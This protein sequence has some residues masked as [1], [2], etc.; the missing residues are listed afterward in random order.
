MG[1]RRGAAD[2]AAGLAGGVLATLVLHPLDFV[3]IQ[4]QVTG[5]RTGARA[6][7]SL[8]ARVV[9]TQGVRGLYR[10]AA[11]NI[12]GSGLAWG[13]YFFGYELIK[14]E[15]RGLVGRPLGA[16]EH[17]LA[18]VTAGSRSHEEEKR[19]KKGRGKKEGRKE[20]RMKE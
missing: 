12:M 17:M 14:G 1:E 18:A 6:T 3:K 11:P 7:R 4:L 19:M 16:R 15:L 5:E 20:G 2:L 9:A 8:V 10:G 13:S